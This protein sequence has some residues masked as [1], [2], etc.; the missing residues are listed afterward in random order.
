MVAQAHEVG[1]NAA[2]ASESVR[3][4]PVELMPGVTRLNALTK[5]GASCTTIA[6]LTGMSI[7]Q[8]YILIEHLNIPRAEQGTVSGDLSFW[9][10]V[11]MLL[12]LIPCGIL[13]DRIGRRPVYVMGIL[14]LGISWGLTPFATTAGELL[15]YRIIFA[16]GVAATTSTLSTM[17][18]DYPVDSSR[19]KYIGLTGM[20][21][22]IGTIFAAKAL[23]AIPDIMSQRGYDAVTGGTVMF[24]TMAF[25]C[26]VTAALAQLGLKAGTPVKQRDR[27]PARELYKSGW[28]AAGNNRRIALSYAAAM[29]ARSDVVIKG[30]FLALWAIQS[31]REL[32]LSPA[33]AMAQFG[34]VIAVMYVV[35]FCSSPLFGWFIDKVDRMTAMCV[36]LATAAAGYLSMAFV[37]SPLDPAMIPYL[38]LLTLGTGWMVK[39]QMALVGQ[40]APV[41]ERGSVISMAQLFGALGILIFTA[42]GGRIFDAW[43]PWAPFVLVGSYQATLLV[44]AIIIRLTTA[45]QGTAPA[46]ARP[47]AA[48]TA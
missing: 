28:R 25:I 3:L 8:G 14:L 5:L 47:R 41:R 46:G 1:T 4:G 16:V 48:E 33:A 15:A 20:L 23:G 45:T 31:G 39:A 13:A 22:V 27:L 44:I 6:A 10:E 37:T 26:F 9:T 18:N 12:T 2:A 30:L 11:I 40:E 43:G 24:G 38:I 29:A 36:A 34:T 32:S 17:V 42:I 35:S 19:G 7:L 21:N